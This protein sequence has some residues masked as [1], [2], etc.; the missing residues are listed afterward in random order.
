MLQY[1][2]LAS[3][4]EPAPGRLNL[5][6]LPARGHPGM[7]PRTQVEFL[8]SQVVTNDTAR[9]RR[10]FSVVRPFCNFLGAPDILGSLFGFR[11]KI[12]I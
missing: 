3:L 5:P 11:S 10:H 7:F 1:T 2:V 6:R 4:P 12:A 8:R 9:R